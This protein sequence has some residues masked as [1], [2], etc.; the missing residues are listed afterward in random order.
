MPTERLRRLRSSLAVGGFLGWRFLRRA[1]RWTAILTVLVMTLTFLNLVAVS[2]ILVGLIEGS[3]TANRD[4]YTADVFISALPGE[5][6][7]ESSGRVVATVRSAPGV[8][9]YSARTI[10]GATVEANYRTRRDPTVDRD[11]VGASVVGIDPAAEDAVTNLSRYVAEGRYLRPDEEGAILVGANLIDRYS[12]GFGDGFSSLENLYPGDKVLVSMSGKKSGSMYDSFTGVEAETGETAREFVVAGIVDSKVDA[13]S[14]RVFMNE[15]EL[16]AMTGESS[17]D[18]NEVSVRLRPGADAAATKAYLVGAGLD[19]LAKI[20]T[21]REAIPE[22]LEQIQ[23]TFGLLG[24]LI[25]AIGLAVASITIFIVVFVSAV[26]RRKYIGIMKAIGVAPRA[27]VVAYVSQALAYSVAGI[28]IGAAL[29]F[30]F[31]IPFIDAHPIDF[32][33][34]DGILVATAGGTA[35]RAVALLVA[36]VAAGIIPAWLIVRQN[37]LDIILGRK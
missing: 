23:A 9:S 32:P 13:T 35:A 27:I 6:S 5:D 15:R 33:F 2:G 22:F 37:T 36:T 14:I 1:N 29:I 7:I 8:A 28:A 10:A 24:N 30:G 34:S 11:T 3:V 16:R 12:A 26:T 31:L 4:Q 18:V 25:G 19:D 17:G 20:R 21:F